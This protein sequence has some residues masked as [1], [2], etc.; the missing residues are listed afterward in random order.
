VV[1]D[2]SPGKLTRGVGLQVGNQA[3]DVSALLL[4]PN[5]LVEHELVPNVWVAGRHKS[6]Q[7]RERLVVAHCGRDGVVPAM[8]K[9][10]PTAHQIVWVGDI[11]KN[12]LELLDAKLLEQLPV[13]R[14]RRRAPRVE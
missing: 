14:H 6:R 1:V 11:P 7:G 9:D 12:C 4:V 8:A 5:Q 3:V 10:D 13:I 2:L